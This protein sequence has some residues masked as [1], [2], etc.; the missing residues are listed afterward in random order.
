MTYE[1]KTAVSFENRTKYSTQ[2][3]HHV[4]YLN[5][6]NLVLP[7]ENPG[8]KRLKKKMFCETY[9][10]NLVTGGLYSASIQVKNNF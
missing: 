8:F 1:G 4:E 2:C 3:E 9:K 6:K 10:K 5:V 7:K